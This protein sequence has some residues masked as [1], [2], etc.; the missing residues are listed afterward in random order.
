MVK[1]AELHSRPLD[2]SFSDSVNLLS[3]CDGKGNLESNRR[4]PRMSCY[5]FRLMLFSSH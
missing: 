4:M 3:E 5:E 2:T 1:R